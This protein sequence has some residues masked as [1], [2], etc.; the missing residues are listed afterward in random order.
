VKKNKRPEIVRG[1]AQEYLAKHSTCCLRSGQK[2]K[3]KRRGVLEV[4]M[5]FERTQKNGL[6]TS[7]KN[8][9][10]FPKEIHWGK[11]GKNGWYKEL[12]HRGAA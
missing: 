1:K 5:S 11:G 10:I 4:T 2:K 8:D 9:Q 6:G 7:E 3:R 12:F